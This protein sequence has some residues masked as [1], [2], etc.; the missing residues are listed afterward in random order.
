MVPKWLLAVLVVALAAACVGCEKGATT[1]PT[2]AETQ[3]VRSAEPVVEWIEFEG[4]TVKALGYWQRDT[5][6]GMW[7]RVIM[8]LDYPCG[9]IGPLPQ[10]HGRDCT[11]DPDGRPSDEPVRK[12]EW[13]G[14]PTSD[15]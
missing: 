7:F 1:A 6:Q 11:D 15:D 13:A 12:W 2:V 8:I 4:K 3:S 10:G 9:A 5:V 14:D